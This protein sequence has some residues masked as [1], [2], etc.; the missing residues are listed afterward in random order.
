VLRAVIAA[1]GLSLSTEHDAR[2]EAC[3]DDAQLT[4]WATR[5]ATA[6]HVDEVFSEA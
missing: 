1:R 2:I 3:D 5:A 4:R 6:Q